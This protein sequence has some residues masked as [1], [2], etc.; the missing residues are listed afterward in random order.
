MCVCVSAWLGAS[1]SGS[2]HQC[3]KDGDK[4]RKF[5]REEK[6]LKR[7]CNRKSEQCNTRYNRGCGNE[8]EYEKA[9]VRAQWREKMQET[10][11]ATYTENLKERD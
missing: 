9:R 3:R 5:S 6:V 4:K 2:A 7:G 1:T 10:D 11:N 8:S